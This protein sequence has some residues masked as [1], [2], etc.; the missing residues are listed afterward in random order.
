MLSPGSGIQQALDK[1]IELPPRVCGGFRWSD[2]LSFKGLLAG[3][4]MPEGTRLLPPPPMEG[5]VP[6]DELGVRRQDPPPTPCSGAGS[7]GEWEEEARPGLAGSWEL[8]GAQGNSVLAGRA[9]WG[10]LSWGERQEA[11][12]ALSG[13]SPLPSAHLLPPSRPPYGLPSSL[14]PASVVS[15][16]SWPL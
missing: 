6:L 12:L 9:G 7:A 4:V 11:D 10:W 16:L 3:W 15:A 2:L 5:L 13:A 14:I 8:A 1:H